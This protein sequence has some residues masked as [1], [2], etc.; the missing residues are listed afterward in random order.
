MF[1]TEQHINQKALRKAKNSFFKAGMPL[2]K[3]ENVKAR[4]TYKELTLVVGIFVALIIAFTLW[5]SGYRNILDENS[6]LAPTISIPAVVN[7]VVKSVSI[8]WL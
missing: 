7:F 5:G 2:V 3:G 4:F 6:G 1:T 8:L